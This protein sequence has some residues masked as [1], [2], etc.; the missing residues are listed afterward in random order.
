MGCINTDLTPTEYNI[1]LQ[2]LCLLIAICIYGAN[3]G[4]K[5]ALNA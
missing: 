1:A 2:R 5:L 4:I 3:L